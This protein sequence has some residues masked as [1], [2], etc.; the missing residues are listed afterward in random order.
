M[1]L[2]RRRTSAPKERN[3]LL[4]PQQSDHM[5]GFVAFM[6]SQPLPVDATQGFVVGWKDA[7]ESAISHYS[8]L[9]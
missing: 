1:N 3:Y 9:E 4:A 2:E 5:L 6:M 7:R 8:A